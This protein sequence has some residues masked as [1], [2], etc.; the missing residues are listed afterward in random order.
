MLETS[1]QHQVPPALSSLASFSSSSF[2]KAQGRAMSHL[3][4]HA[5]L[6]AVNFACPGNL[7]AMSST[8]LRLEA[9]I[10]SM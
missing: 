5:F 10:T 6:P 2:W 9:R 1:Q 8:L 4:L 7:S 3:T